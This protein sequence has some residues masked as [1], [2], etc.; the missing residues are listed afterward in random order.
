MYKSTGDIAS[1]TKMFGD[2]TVVTD[3]DVK[4]PWLKWRDIAIQRRRPKK[5]LVQAN[6]FE[7][8]EMGLRDLQG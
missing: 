1:A 7:N 3:D 8:G 5:M 2:Y 6:T 4:R